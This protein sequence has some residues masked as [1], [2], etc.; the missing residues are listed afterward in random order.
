MAID[1]DTDIFPLYASNMEGTAEY[2]NDFAVITG[3]VGVATATTAVPGWAITDTLSINDGSGAN[4]VALNGAGGTP[5]TIANDINTDAGVIADGIVADVVE[6]PA[7]FVVRIRKTV[8]T[9]NSLTL[10]N[11]AGTPLADLGLAA[12]PVTGATGGIPF[13]KVDA[14][15]EKRILTTLEVVRSYMDTLRNRNEV[16]NFHDCMSRMLSD[17]AY[18]DVYDDIR[19]RVVGNQPNP[20]FLIGQGISVTT[21]SGTDASVLAATGDLSRPIL[22]HDPGAALQDGRPATA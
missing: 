8:T 5:T 16:R 3:T 1:F 13:V 14:N 15:N 20:T 11:G 18:S 22:R 4:V 6:I 2:Q 10:A 19:A 21:V 17:I 12:G 7:G 9:N